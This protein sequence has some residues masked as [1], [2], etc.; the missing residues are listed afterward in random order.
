MAFKNPEQTVGYMDNI[1]VKISEKYKPPK[2]ILLPTNN[3]RLTV[4][5]INQINYDFQLEQ[6]V[7]E[8]MKDLKLARNQIRNKRESDNTELLNNQQDFKVNQRNIS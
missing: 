5:D 1:P 8:R 4:N 2:R 7:K 3:T 6:S